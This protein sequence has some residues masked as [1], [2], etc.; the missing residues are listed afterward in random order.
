MFSHLSRGRQGPHIL[1]IRDS[2]GPIRLEEAR[3]YA[4]AKALAQVR[5]GDLVSKR[6]HRGQLKDVDLSLAEPAERRPNFVVRGLRALFA[7]KSGDP[8]GELSGDTERA[9]GKPRPWP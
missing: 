8:D 7:G 1:L 3:L 2:D 9:L 6:P 5:A 4:W